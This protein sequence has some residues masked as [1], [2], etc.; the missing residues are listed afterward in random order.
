MDSA[1]EQAE[2]ANRLKDEFL[3]TVSHELRTPLNSILGW[4]QMYRRGQFGGE[5]PA[6]AR[7]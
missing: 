3:A 4:A 1:R 5:V 7:F 6:G 2:N